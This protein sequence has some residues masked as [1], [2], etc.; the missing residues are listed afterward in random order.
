MERSLIWID[1]DGTGWACSNCRW[2]FAV[3]TLLSGKE[4]MAAYDRLASAKFRDHKCEAEMGVPAP[5]KPEGKKKDGNALADRARTLIMRGYKPKDAVELVLRETAM[6]S[7]ND[8]KT[9]E[10]ARADAEDF[11]QRIRKG[12]I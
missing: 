6:E 8:P 9:V 10:R 1:G 3:P 5:A 11:L 12:L 4:A 2:R 7:G